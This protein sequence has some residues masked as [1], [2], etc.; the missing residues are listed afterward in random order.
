MSCS[1]RPNNTLA[2]SIISALF[3]LYLA[4]WTSAWA[5]SSKNVRSQDPRDAGR[6]PRALISNCKGC[7]WQCLN[8]SC[9]SSPQLSFSWL[10]KLAT[11]YEP[12][13][14]DGCQL[15]AGRDLSVKSQRLLCC[16]FR[17]QGSLSRIAN[18]K[19]HQPLAGL[20]RVICAL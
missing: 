16:W 18:E 11:W 19:A 14:V 1:K 5:D 12:F 6:A 13:Q 7:A 4:S 9:S 2:H 20:P 8:L 17:S 3:C 10:V 15:R